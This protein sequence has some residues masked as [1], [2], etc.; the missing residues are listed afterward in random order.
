[1]GDAGK[2]CRSGRNATSSDSRPLLI[3]LRGTNTTQD[4]VSSTVMSLSE[5]RSCFRFDVAEVQ[6]QGK[7]GY[8]GY[9]I[10]QGVYRKG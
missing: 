7:N 8:E 4:V 2:W 5:Y 1:M 9:Q 3:A 10:P 6:E